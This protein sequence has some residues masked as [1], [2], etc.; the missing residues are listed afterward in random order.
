MKKYR[1]WVIADR[2]GKAWLYANGTPVVYD[3]RKSAAVDA[4]GLHPG[5]GWRPRRATLVVDAE[6]VK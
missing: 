4:S 5:R 6:A 2:H 1:V 3:C